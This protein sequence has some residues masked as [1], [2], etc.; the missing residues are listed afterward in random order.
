MSRERLQK[1]LAQAGLCS[2]RGAEELMRQG[3]VQL[4]G[5]PAQP[6]DQADPA[7]DQIL[8]DGRPLPQRQ[9][10]LTLLLHKPRGVHC[11]CHDP[12]GRRTVLDLLPAE[13]AHGTGLHPVGRLD[14][15]SRGALLLSNHGSLTLALTHPRYNHSKRYRI[16][17]SGCPTDNTLQRWSAGVPLDGNP[18]RSV[19]L[20]VLKREA[21]RTLLELTMQEGRNRQIRRTAELLGHRVED[22]MRIGIGP[23][24]LGPLASGDWRWLH[25]EEEAALQAS[26]TAPTH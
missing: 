11:T 4:N 7:K 16:W 14:A 3:R 13:L 5:Q 24:Q 8:V 19:Q 21:Q 2:R 17:I 18:S 22:L 15:D 20:S 26:T 10:L 23:V 12:R 1:L 6:G 9:R 25:P